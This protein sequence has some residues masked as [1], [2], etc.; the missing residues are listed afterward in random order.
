[1]LIL[2]L[3][4]EAAKST[5]PLERIWFERYPWTSLRNGYRKLRLRCRP[6][7]NGLKASLRSNYLTYLHSKLQFAI[8]IQNPNSG[9][10]RLII[11]SHTRAL[12][13]KSVVEGKSVSV[14][15]DLGD[16]RIFKKIKIINH[17]TL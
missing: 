5:S 1:M 12:D 4:Q 13:R 7:L 16:P 8:S 9:P 3:S 11:S 15:V 10:V 2:I 14:R 17:I 6:L